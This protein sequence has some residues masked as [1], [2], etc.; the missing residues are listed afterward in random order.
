MTG[1]AAIAAYVY[2][3]NYQVIAVCHQSF[4]GRY[5]LKL[6]GHSRKSSCSAVRADTLSW[7]IEEQK[8]NERDY[9]SQILTS[10][11]EKDG[12]YYG[13]MTNLRLAHQTSIM[14]E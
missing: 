2:N 11:G 3:N 5:C 6:L 13:G 14:Q 10:P 8:D 7:S 9:L 4:V 12:Q 1:S